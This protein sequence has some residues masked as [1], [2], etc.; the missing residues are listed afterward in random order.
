MKTT[1]KKMR[2]LII[3]IVFALMLALIS[4]SIIT[5]GSSGNDFV[6][7]DLIPTIKSV[8]EQYS[9][10]PELVE[11]M[12]EAE[13]GGISTVRNGSCIGLMQVS[14]KWHT[15]RAQR[16]GV[17]LNTDEGNIM[18]GVD[19][20]ME[21][22]EESDDLYYVL[23]TYNGQSDAAEG[24]ANDYA[25]KILNRAYELEVIHGKHRYENQ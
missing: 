19:Y 21:L 1:L 25:D 11:A 20:L 8:S 24:K 17:D 14:T 3:L 7:P 23:A 10:S 12:I 16:L 5:Y 15:D 18:A 4:G 6:R 13:S 22:A 2:R 9:V